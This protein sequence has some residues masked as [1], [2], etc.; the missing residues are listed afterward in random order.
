MPLHVSSRPYAPYAP[1]ASYPCNQSQQ[2]TTDQSPQQAASPAGFVHTQKQTHTSVLP[3]VATQQGRRLMVS[4]WKSKANVHCGPNVHVNNPHYGRR[5]KRI[6]AVTSKMA[7]FSSF[8]EE[9]ARNLEGLVKHEW[10]KRGMLP[11]F[12]HT[13]FQSLKF[14][15][16]IAYKGSSREL[17]DTC[18]WITAGLVSHR[19]LLLL[20]LSLLLSLLLT[21]FFLVV[22]ID[23][24]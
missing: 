14:H 8:R 24:L 9:F 5:I 21:N 23:I 10:I 3:K 16:F 18:D 2:I 22:F 17:S 11:C 7:K 15:N 6:K 13:S 1:N 20:L 19:L 4:S 12:I